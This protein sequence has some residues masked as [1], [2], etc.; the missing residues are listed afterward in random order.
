MGPIDAIKTGLTKSFQLSGR[1][2]RSEFWWLVTCLAL[3]V[4]LVVVLSIVEPSTDP[5]V[6][7]WPLLLLFPLVGLTILLT[8]GVRRYRD[9][10]ISPMFWPALMLVATLPIAVL[11]LMVADIAYTP[12]LIFVLTLFGGPLL[13]LCG[14]GLAALPSAPNPNE[15]PS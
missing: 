9:A 7:L 6:Y 15:V 13:V 3:P 2:T 14:C 5:I 10:G 12:T 8:A 1:A 11:I 4:I